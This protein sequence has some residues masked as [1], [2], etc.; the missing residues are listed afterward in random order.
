MCL[1]FNHKCNP[2]IG[3][4]AVLI[5]VRFSL[6]IVFYCRLGPAESPVI[7]IYFSIYCFEAQALHDLK[8]ELRQRMNTLV[9]QPES[10]YIILQ[11]PL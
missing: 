9:L 1:K 3:R 7:F 4:V 6:D 5:A 10:G 11:P 8:K 2:C